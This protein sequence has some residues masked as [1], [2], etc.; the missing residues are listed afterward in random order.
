MLIKYLAIFLPIDV[1]KPI[2]VT[3]KKFQIAL[4]MLHKADNV[5]YNTLL[6]TGSERYSIVVINSPL[7]LKKIVQAQPVP[8]LYI[9]QVLLAFNTII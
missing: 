4:G 2:K 7:F 5:L 8:V 3:D 9:N 6:W 1:K